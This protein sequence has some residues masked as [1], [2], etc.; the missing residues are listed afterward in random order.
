MKLIG[1]DPWR[2]A[3]ELHRRIAY[4]HGDITLWTNLTGGEVID[5]WGGLNV[6][7][8]KFR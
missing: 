1:G 3:V 5:F 8:I 4:V 2:D 6:D 7:L